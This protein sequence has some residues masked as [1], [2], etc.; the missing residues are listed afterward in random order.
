MPLVLRFPNITL[1]FCPSLL[2]NRYTQ[3]YKILPPKIH[4]S[5]SSEAPLRDCEGTACPPLPAHLSPD[6]GS[7][8]QLSSMPPVPGMSRGR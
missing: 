8:G 7:R 2:Y 5:S 4:P 6:L 3:S 1:A